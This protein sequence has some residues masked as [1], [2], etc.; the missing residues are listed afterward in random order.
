[1]KTIKYTICTVLLSAILIGC[2]EK[3]LEESPDNRLQIDSLDKAYELLVYA[4]NDGSYAFLE[5]LTDNVGYIA[6]NSHYPGLDNELFN[7]EESQIESQDSPNYYWNNGYRAIAQANAVLHYIDNLAGNE[8][9]RNHIKGEALLFRAY[10]HFMLVNIFAKQYDTATAPS[11]QGIPYVEKLETDLIVSYENNTVQEVYDFIERDMVKGLQLI[12]DSFI[13]EGKKY[14]FTKK[15]AQAFASRFYLW[16]GNNQKCI[17]YSS[18]VLGGNP[19]Q[20]IKDYDKILYAGGADESGVAFIDTGDRSNLMVA[21]RETGYSLYYNY[22]DRLTLSKV[23]EIYNAQKIGLNADARAQI[24]YYGNVDY[25]SL[26]IAKNYRYFKRNSLSSN[27]GLPYRIDILFRGE[28]V[29]LNRAEAYSNLSMTEEG[30]A[31]LELLLKNRYTDNFAILKEFYTWEV[32]YGFLED[33]AGLDRAGVLA[34]L[35]IKERRREFTEEGMRWFDIKRYGYSVSRANG[36]VLTEN[37]TRK[38]LPIPATAQEALGIN[39]E[40]DTETNN[41]GKLEIEALITPEFLELTKNN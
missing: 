31:D 22:K 6:E 20:Y 7:W 35:I 41:N 11:D 40:S 24:I 13:T 26:R 33:I 2:S 9:Y 17:D 1:M 16:T 30:V 38:A 14:H 27:I 18:E 4:S 3:F 23:Y 10:N 39:I 15:A 19:E 36:N 12:D 21:R 29:L 25:T 28:E 5:Q 37:D 8:D 32:Y 34:D